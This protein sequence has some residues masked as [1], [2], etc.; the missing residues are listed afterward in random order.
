MVQNCQAYF[1]GTTSKLNEHDTVLTIPKIEII[2]TEF[3]CEKC[4]NAEFFSGP[5]FPLFRLNT[6]IYSLN[7]RI[8]FEYEKM[9]TRK[10]ICI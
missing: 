6:K 10:K 5:Y 3:L 9:E 4:L 2:S 1:L 8:Q 7:L